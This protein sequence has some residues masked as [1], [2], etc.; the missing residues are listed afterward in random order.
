MLGLNV[1]QQEDSRW[2]ISQANYV[3]EVTKF[4]ATHFNIPSKTTHLLCWTEY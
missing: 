4:S 2:L 1:K 3:P